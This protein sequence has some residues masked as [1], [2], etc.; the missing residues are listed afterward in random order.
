MSVSALIVDKASRVVQI[1]H[2]ID[3]ACVSSAWLSALE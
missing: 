3:Q 1:F 2:R